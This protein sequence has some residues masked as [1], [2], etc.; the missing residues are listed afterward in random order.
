M[1]LQSILVGHRIDFGAI[2]SQGKGF[3]PTHVLFVELCPKRPY[4]HHLPPV[5]VTAS[6]ARVLGSVGQKW[7]MNAGLLRIWPN[8]NIILWLPDAKNWLIRKD[9][10]AGKD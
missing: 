2:N 9:P 10:D 3:S 1:F 5:T 7:Q 4:H 8:P 6:S